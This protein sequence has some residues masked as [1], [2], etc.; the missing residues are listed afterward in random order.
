[1]PKCHRWPSEAIRG[2]QRRSEAIRGDQEA[3]KRRS[4]VISANCT[5]VPEWSVGRHQ[6]SSLFNSNHQPSS[7]VISRHQ[8]SS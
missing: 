1:M 5:Y 6:Q 8:P 4:E 3:I 2:D 7:A